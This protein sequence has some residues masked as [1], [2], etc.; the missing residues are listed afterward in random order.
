MGAVGCAFQTH[1]RLRQKH[2]GE[3]SPSPAH[4]IPAASNSTSPHVTKGAPA[5]GPA[6]CGCLQLKVFGEGEGLW[7]VKQNPRWHQYI[8]MW[9]VILRWIIFEGGTILL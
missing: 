3:K 6:A 1:A 7:P 2:P 8:L 9:I 5:V 4:A